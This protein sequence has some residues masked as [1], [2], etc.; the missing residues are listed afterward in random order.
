[1]A[2]KKIIEIGHRGLKLDNKP[3]ID[4]NSPKLKDLVRNLFDTMKKVDLI[5]IAAPQ[6]EA[7]QI[8]IIKFKKI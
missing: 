5:G 3:I 7:F 1:M 4:F 2:I 6:I 8:S